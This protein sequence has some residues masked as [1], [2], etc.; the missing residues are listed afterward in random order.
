MV[1]PTP[2]RVETENAP[3]SGP[4][5]EPSRE[6]GEAEDSAGDALSTLESTPTLQ[7]TRKTAR[8]RILFF[9][10]V[11]GTGLTAGFAFL[12]TIFTIISDDIAR[13]PSRMSFFPMFTYY[14]LTNGP[15]VFVGVVLAAAA[16][17][18]IRS[19]QRAARRTARA[20][21]RALSR[22]AAPPQ[23]R[24]PQDRS[25][26]R[27]PPVLRPVERSAAEIVE[28]LLKDLNLELEP[29]RADD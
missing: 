20:V 1:P 2:P 14:L 8:F 29:R 10:V 12:A 27:R 9:A 25:P 16:D 26:Q 19:Q 11:A 24:S 5:D 18:L 6:P 3:P 22:G 21:E 15:M 4:A 28:P 23:D 17:A 13:N 7:S